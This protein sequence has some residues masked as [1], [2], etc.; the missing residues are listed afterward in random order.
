[1][2]ISGVIHSVCEVLLDCWLE[3]SGHKLVLPLLIARI[4]RETTQ[5]I[6]RELYCVAV[7]DSKFLI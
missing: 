5:V 4:V 7:S 1:M 3:W 6:L 2:E